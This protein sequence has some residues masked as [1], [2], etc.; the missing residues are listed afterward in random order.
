MTDGPAPFQNASGPSW[1]N[2][3]VLAWSRILNTALEHVRRATQGGG[4]GTGD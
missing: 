4:G 2:S 3:G 1:D